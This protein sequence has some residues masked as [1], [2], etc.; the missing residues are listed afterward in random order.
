MW[1]VSLDA[2]DLSEASKEAYRYKYG[3]VQMYMW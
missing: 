3:Y 1:G 2:V